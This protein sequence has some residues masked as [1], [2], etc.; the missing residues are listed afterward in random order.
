MLN[1]MPLLKCLCYQKRNSVDWLDVILESIKHTASLFYVYSFIT[2]R[3][4]ELF[5]AIL[6]Y[7]IAGYPEQ[8]NLSLEDLE[9]CGRKSPRIIR[10]M[11]QAVALTCA[12]YIGSYMQSWLEPISETPSQRNKVYRCWDIERRAIKYAYWWY[13]SSSK[14]GILLGFTCITLCDMRKATRL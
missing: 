1:S 10:N 6:Y 12:S 8:L 9:P 2:M 13:V 4:I 3:L 14:Y 5:S 11:T 7:C